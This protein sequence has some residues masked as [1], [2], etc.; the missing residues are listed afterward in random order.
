MQQFRNYWYI[1]AA[2][3]AA[4]WITSPLA[5][6]EE[7]K[8]T[9]IIQAS[10]EKLVAA[11]N[12]GKGDELA[13]L[14]L[15]EGEL[16]DEHGTIYQGRKEI[17]ELLKNF[18]TKFPGAKLTIEVDSI[19]VIGPVAIEEGTRYTT[20]KDDGER[21]LV[22]YTAVRTKVGNEWPIVSIRDASDD[23]PPTPN[24]LLQPLAWLVGDWVN[25]GSDAAV[26]ISY[27]WSEDKNFLLGDFDIKRGG[28][29]IMK[30]TQ[31][32][33]WDPLTGKVRS[34][35]FDADGGYADAT[36][37]LVEDAWVIK[38]NAVTPEGDTGSATV[39][40]RP[41]DKDRFVMQGTERIAGDERIDNFE[42]TIVKPPPTPSK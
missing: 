15:P 33:G 25:E 2:I 7:D 29:V 27:K 34:W 39:T 28:E 8:D 23:D 37:T 38:S 42:M 22:R 10:D 6:A 18:F 9:K 41:K 17:G 20:T 30:S 40:L 1:L 24:E 16:I 26:K 19:R 35:M 5:Q 11:F 21:S 14:F 3:A 31:R 13:S 12:A 36:W 32:I 4:C